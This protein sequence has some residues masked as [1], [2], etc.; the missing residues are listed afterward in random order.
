MEL[1][2]KNICPENIGKWFRFEDFS[3]KI[4]PLIYESGSYWFY[5]HCGK[6]KASTIEHSLVEEDIIVTHK[7]GGIGKL[8]KIENL[9]GILTYGVYWLNK[10]NHTKFENHYYWNI[11][12][13]VIV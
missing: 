9:N 13:N 3:T 12:L 5:S 6:V 11:S 7:R 8:N 1:K 4:S 10:A 2:L